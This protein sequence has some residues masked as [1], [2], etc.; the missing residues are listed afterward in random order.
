MPP[1]GE[2]IKGPKSSKLETKNPTKK[3]DS[4]KR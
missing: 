4:L 2:I 3:L 1:E